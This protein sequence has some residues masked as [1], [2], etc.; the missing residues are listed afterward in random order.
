[1]AST[2]H[3]AGESNVETGQS[4]DMALDSQRKPSIPNSQRQPST[5]IEM[6][7]MAKLQPNPDYTSTD[8]A[9]NGHVTISHEADYEL[10]KTNP[11]DEQ[12]SIPPATQHS[13][14]QGPSATPILFTASE[15]PINP[16]P[17]SQTREA[18]RPAI[19]PAIDTSLPT[20]KETE[21]E[22]PVLHIT[23]LLTTGARHPFRLDQR[24]LKKRSVEVEDNNPINMS[25]YKLKELILRDWREGMPLLPMSL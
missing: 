17:S 21:V 6:A 20:S 9:S 7:E 22:G 10:Q 8:V 19:G 2:E 4:L 23:L 5:P 18:A 15:D 24:Y 13:A 11:R 1:M 3:S 25:L 12:V 16:K 14:T